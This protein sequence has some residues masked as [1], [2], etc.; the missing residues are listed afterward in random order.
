M[1][2]YD[3]GEFLYIIINDGPTN[4]LRNESGSSSMSAE[5][6]RDDKL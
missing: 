3:R 4:L 2:Q 6:Q 5:E 1:N